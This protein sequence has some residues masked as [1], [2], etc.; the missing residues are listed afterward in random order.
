MR[1]V[2]DD[3]DIDETSAPRSSASESAPAFDASCA[4]VVCQHG[5]RL[6]AAT[7]FKAEAATAPEGYGDERCVR[8]TPRI[9]TDVPIA[10]GLCDED[11]RPTTVSPRHAPPEPLP[12]LP[13]TPRRPM[14][15][16]PAVAVHDERVP[17]ASVYEGRLGGGGPRGR[18]VYWA[19]LGCSIVVALLVIWLRRG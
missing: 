11:Q 13:M 10:R 7:T 16:S 6:S 17:V 19:G 14:L 15:R 3:A 9:V 2:G 4:R 1:L 8:A 5:R 12:P 18:A